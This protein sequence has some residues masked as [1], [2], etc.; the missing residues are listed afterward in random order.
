M[1]IIIALLIPFAVA[2]LGFLYNKIKN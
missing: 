1:D 2:A